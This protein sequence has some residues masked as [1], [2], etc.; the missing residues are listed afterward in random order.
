MMDKMRNLLFV[1]AASGEGQF[2]QI[3]DPELE[4]HLA[5][6]GFRCHCCYLP[7]LRRSI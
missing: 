4:K 2:R 3:V 6:K 5:A 1:A 7:Q